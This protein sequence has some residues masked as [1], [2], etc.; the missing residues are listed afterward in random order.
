VFDV[1]HC[2]DDALWCC[3][4]WWLCTVVMTDDALWWLC[5]VVMI[6]CG[7]DALW[8]CTVVGCTVVMMHCGGALWCGAL[9]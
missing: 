1:V 2:D 6:H 4:L 9:W 3:A 7:Y 5:T 8:W